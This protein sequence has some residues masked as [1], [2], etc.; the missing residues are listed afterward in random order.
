MKER[1]QPILEK[2]SSLIGTPLVSPCCLL[3]SNL[4]DRDGQLGVVCSLN[5]DSVASRLDFPVDSKPALDASTLVSS[6]VAEAETALTGS[7]K[8]GLEGSGPSLQNCQSH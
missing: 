3:F 7:L 8:A 4:P 6:L 2:Y 5:S 1:V